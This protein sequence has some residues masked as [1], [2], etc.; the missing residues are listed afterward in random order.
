MFKGQFQTPQE[1]SAAKTSHEKLIEFLEKRGLKQK[2]DNLRNHGT[3][4]NLHKNQIDDSGAKELAA[5]LKANNHLTM[6]FLGGNKIGNTGAKFIAEALKDN[7][8]LTHLDL[9]GNNISKTILETI[10]EYL[11]RNKTIAEKKAQNLNTEKE[12]E[13][14]Y[15]EQQKQILSKNN[16]LAET[17][18]KFFHDP[19]SVSLCYQIIID[20]FAKLVADKLKVIKTITAIDFMGSTISDQSIKII[21]E[22]L[23]VSLSNKKGALNY[24]KK[25]PLYL[26]FFMSYYLQ[27]YSY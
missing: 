16:E 21:T 20:D 13:K 5:A 11:Q 15:E 19:T 25:G 23:K 3:M 4:L 9:S 18:N 1:V 24:V 2:A 7:D 27:I 26:K 10:N 14:K 22:A 17:V 12:V 8:S 6:L